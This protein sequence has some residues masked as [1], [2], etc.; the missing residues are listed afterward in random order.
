M[1]TRFMRNPSPLTSWASLS[2]ENCNK[3]LLLGIGYVIHLPLALALLVDQALP[4]LEY[5]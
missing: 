2:V 4:T 1:K 3:Q 5:F